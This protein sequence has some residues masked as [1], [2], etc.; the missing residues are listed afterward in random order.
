MFHDQILPGNIPPLS[1]TCPPL[2][3]LPKI[4]ISRLFTEIAST[5][6]NP[7]INFVSARLLFPD[8]TAL[9][10]PSPLLLCLTHPDG[11]VASAA[12]IGVFSDAETVRWV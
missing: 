3:P 12:F 5:N 6:L 9:I 11:E 10:P 8:A 2:L 1:N 7:V 4:F